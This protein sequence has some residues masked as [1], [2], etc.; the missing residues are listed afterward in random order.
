MIKNVGKADKLARITVGVLLLGLGA[1]DVIGWWGLIGLLP[2][3]TDVLN[4]CPA[5]T[6]LGVATCKV[7]ARDER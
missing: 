7:Q 3:A 1:A 2:L 6:L 5:Y 4:W